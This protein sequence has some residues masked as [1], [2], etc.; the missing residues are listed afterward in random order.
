MLSDAQIKR[1]WENM[2]SAEIR[3]NYFAELAER[4]SRRQRY[5]T[6]GVLFLSSGAFASFAFRDLPSE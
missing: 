3:A 5:A 2:L 1:L 6:W 4:F